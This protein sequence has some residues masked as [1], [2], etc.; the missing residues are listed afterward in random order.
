M[1]L[2]DYFDF[3]ISPAMLYPGA[4]ENDIVHA[5]AMLGCCGMEEFSLIEAYLPEDPHIRKLEISIIK[6]SKKRLI[7][8]CPVQLQQEYPYNAGSSEPNVRKNA[9][10]FTKKHMDYAAEAGC[11]KMILTSCLD[12]GAKS[13]GEVYKR[14]LEYFTSAAEYAHSLGIFL[15]IEPAE[16]GVHKNLLLGPTD[17]CCAF[18]QKLRTMGY[19]NVGVMID[20][21]HLPLMGEN[22]ED[23][24]AKISEVGLSHIH[25]GDAVTDPSRPFYGHTH[26]PLETAGGTFGMKEYALFFAMLVEKRY[27]DLSGQTAPNAVSL[28]VQSYPGV[29][30]ETSARFMYEKMCHAFEQAIT[31]NR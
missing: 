30:P 23:S 28:E 6:G 20:T 29:S 19:S 15:I 9:L 10:L 8:N 1:R 31:S 2:L 12:Q 21:A 7:Y 5:R 13:R 3:G 14:F 17:E 25:L 11:T 4:F 27:L 24:L 22:F 26:P 18:I 16:R